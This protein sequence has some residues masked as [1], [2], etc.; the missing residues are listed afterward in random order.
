MKGDALLLFSDS[1][2]LTSTA[3]SNVIDLGAYGDEVAKT[4]ALLVQGEGTFAPT[5]AG[6]TVALQT[7]SN[8]SNWNTV[9]TFPK[10][11]GSDIN[12]GKRIVNF[13]EL[14][15]GIKRYIRLSYTVSDG[16]FTAGKVF[17]MLTPS[18]EIGN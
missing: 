15:F 10:I 14:P 3:N 7:S 9:F 12:G 6:V 1:A 11:T 18:R 17:A 4:L 2:A 16:P 8:N 5:T 13:A